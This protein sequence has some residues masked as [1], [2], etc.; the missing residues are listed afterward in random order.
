M[1]VSLTTSTI[2]KEKE[3]DTLAQ[4]LY[5]TLDTGKRSYIFK[6]QINTSSTTNYLLWM[7][8]TGLILLHVH[9]Q[10]VYCNCGKWHWFVRVW[11]VA[12]TINLDRQTYRWTE[13][14]LHV[15]PKIRY[16]LVYNKVYIQT[17][18]TKTH[19]YRLINVL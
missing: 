7:S 14:L 18:T 6:I 5:S 17:C 19:V 1:F 11:G 15:Y 9:P 3:C 8:S 13:R 16:L 12:F 10:G 2:A 4:S